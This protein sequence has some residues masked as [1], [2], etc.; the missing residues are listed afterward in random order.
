MAI[1]EIPIG[2]TK[3]MGVGGESISTGG[4]GEVYVLSQ[5]QVTSACVGIPQEIRFFQAVPS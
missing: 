4:E 1:D 2:K 5:E 3:G